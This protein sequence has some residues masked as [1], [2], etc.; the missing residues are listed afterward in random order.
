MATKIL[1]KIRD[2][3]NGIDFDL[4]KSGNARF[5][6]QKCT[7]D[8]LSSVAEAILEFTKEKKDCTFTVKDIWS[9]SFANDVM[10]GQFQKPA[11]SHP[12]AQNEYNKVFSQPIKLLDYAQILKSEE[13]RGPATTYKINDIELLRYI[14]LNDNKSL[15][16]IISYLT[17]VIKDSELT[18]LFDNF[19][20]K[21]NKQSFNELKDG[22][23][24]FIIK[25]T[26]I[27]G[28]TEVRRIFA[29][30]INP[31]AFK[32][33]TL[34]TKGGRLSPIPIGYA[35]LFY[36]RLNF[37]DIKKPKGDFRLKQL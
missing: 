22:Y 21:Q 23:C 28:D 15:N 11:V 34:G 12:G 16:F 6:D 19:F 4:R 35:E 10:V 1:N 17:K 30:I 33:K 14:S 13:R 37:R 7:P 27:N 24:N 25:Y 9:S 20:T 36:N 32:N 29:K 31:L 5:I 26:P 8:I 18:E 3:L 2:H